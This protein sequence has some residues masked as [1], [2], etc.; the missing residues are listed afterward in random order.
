MSAKASETMTKTEIQQNINRILTEELHLSVPTVDTDL[1]DSGLIDSLAF[2]E[3]LFHIEQDFNVS[4]DLDTLD[5]DNLRSVT[6]IA[7]FVGQ[8]V[9]AA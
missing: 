6:N 8:F 2:V 3:L 5:L 7:S 9:A 4:V 1:I